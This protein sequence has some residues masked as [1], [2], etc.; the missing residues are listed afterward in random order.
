ME[1][2]T[3][4]LGAVTDT[5][6]A[7][8]LVGVSL[9]IVAT[10]AAFLTST[11]GN[12]FSATRPR[13]PHSQVDDKLSK[14]LS[15]ENVQVDEV[16]LEDY[17]RVDELRLLQVRYERQA[18]RNALSFNLL[19]FGQYIIGALLA[20]QFVQTNLDAAYVGLLGVLVLLS[21]AI[22]QRFRPDVL[23]TQAK[24]RLTKCSRII[25]HLEDGVFDIR[26]K[27]RDAAHLLELRTIASHGMD[28]LERNE[29]TGVESY[30][31][32]RRQQQED[33]SINGEA[34]KAGVPNRP[35]IGSSKSNRDG[36]AGV[37]V[38]ADATGL[39]KNYDDQ[40]SRSDEVATA[41]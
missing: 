39:D 23:S 7:F 26:G 17:A 2:A 34:G 27:V 13:K 35:A 1:Q 22:Q 14:L 24:Y 3:N 31:E 9:A 10:I 38:P 32:T 20:S 18:R 28:E 21:S 19:V 12:I 11:I 25:R 29:Y 4:L 6:N 16:E 8:D 36:P 37:Q 30:Y 33:M 40:R 41:S 15:G 5:I